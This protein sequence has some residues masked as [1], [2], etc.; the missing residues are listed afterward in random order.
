MTK[1]WP[2]CMVKLVGPCAGIYIYFQSEVFP[3]QQNVCLHT[4]KLRTLCFMNEHFVFLGLCFV[5]K[6]EYKREATAHI[7]QA[8]LY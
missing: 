7:D 8:C 2:K 1:Y 5:F 6:F 4:G 3:P